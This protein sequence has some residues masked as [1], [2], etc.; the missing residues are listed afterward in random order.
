LKTLYHIQLTVH[1]S[2]ANS[3][4]SSA[5]VF[6]E[7]EE[8]KTREFSHFLSGRRTPDNLRGTI[9]A[10]DQLNHLPSPWSCLWYDTENMFNATSLEVTTVITSFS[11]HLYMLLLDR[12][13]SAKMLLSYSSSNSLYYTSLRYEVVTVLFDNDVGKVGVCVVHGKHILLVVSLRHRA[14]CTGINYYFSRNLQVLSGDQRMKAE[15]SALGPGCSFLPTSAVN[16]NVESL[17]S[18]QRHSATLTVEKERY[19]ERKAFLSLM[20]QDV[21]IST[22]NGH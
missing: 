19:F 15:L 1:P 10:F 4:K 8:H 7:V 20:G 17:T 22:V 11:G 16:L 6:I 14:S 12:R 5:Y 18:P 2:F 13:S 9:P 21:G 3:F